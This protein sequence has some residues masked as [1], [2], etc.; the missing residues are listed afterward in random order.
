MLGDLIG[1]MK[2]KVTGIRVLADRLES[3]VQG[4]GKVWGTDE[5]EVET[6]TSTPRPDGS[7]LGE[8]QGLITTKDGDMIM[9]KGQ[10]IGIPTGKGQAAS[11]RG[12]IH[13]QT[14]S[15]KFVKAN[16]TVGVF[17]YDIDQEGNVHGKIWEWK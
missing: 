12:A 11:F 1:E 7:V 5:N 10:G 15:Q 13:Y 14:A 3:T 8:G 2:G 9:F 17:E 4:S 16:R 6:F